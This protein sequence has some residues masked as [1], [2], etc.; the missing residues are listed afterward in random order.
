M[1]KIVLLLLTS[2]L[3]FAD[4]PLITQCNECHNT[5][6]APPYEKI[7]KHYL[8]KYSSKMRVKK[9]MIDFLKA[10]SEE[11]SAMPRGMKRRFSPDEH[12][13]F[14]NKNL[15]AALRYIIEQEDVITKLKLVQD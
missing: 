12:Q 9:A 13:V 15:E 10:P 8:L 1:E 4:T 5:H 6:R 11:K 2:V 7:Y 3:L 14:N